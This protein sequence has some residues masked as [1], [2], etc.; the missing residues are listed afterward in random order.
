MAFA[1]SSEIGV[2]KIFYATESTEF[3]E[4]TE[5]PSTSG[6]LCTKIERPI[7]RMA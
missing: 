2:K 3:A 7:S 5:N 1:G 4:K 6:V